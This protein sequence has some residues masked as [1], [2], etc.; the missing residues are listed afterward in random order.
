MHCPDAWI[1]EKIAIE[2]AKVPFGKLRHER[3]EFYGVQPF[4]TRMQ[5]GPRSG[6][7]GGYAQRCHV[8]GLPMQ[9]DG[10]KRLPLLIG[11]GPRTA[12]SIAVVENDAPIVRL[13]LGDR[14]DTLASNSDGLNAL[15]APWLNLRKPGKGAPCADAKDQRPPEAPKR[16]VLRRGRIEI[17]TA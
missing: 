10:Q 17:N 2:W 7:S 15:S 11:R 3:R 6:T 1:G 5:E 14:H 4:D 13:P 12:Q 9:Q 16:H 8:L